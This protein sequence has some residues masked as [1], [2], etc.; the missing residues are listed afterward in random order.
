MPTD[1]TKIV[2]KLSLSTAQKEVLE[3][4][5]AHPLPLQEMGTG[6][7]AAKVRK[8]LFTLLALFRKP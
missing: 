6:P 2:L 3:Q 1:N 5:A 8:R 4:A 7:T